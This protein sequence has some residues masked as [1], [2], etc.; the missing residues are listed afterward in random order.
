MRGFPPRFPLGSLRRPL[1]FLGLADMG[2]K[3]TGPYKTRGIYELASAINE[4]YFTAAER[5]TEISLPLLGIPIR[6]DSKQQQLELN[7]N[8]NFNL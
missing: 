6:L 1:Q 8:N 5:D 7:V 4:G 2:S 3:A